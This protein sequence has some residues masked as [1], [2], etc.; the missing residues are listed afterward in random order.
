MNTPFNEVFIKDSDPTAVVASNDNSFV[1]QGRFRSWFQLGIFWF[2]SILNCEF[3]KGRKPIVKV[4]LIKDFS[5]LNG[6]VFCDDVPV[7]SST[8][9]AREAFGGFV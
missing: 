8:N 2:K 1:H 4:A 6:S 9:W 5:F 7:G 3:F